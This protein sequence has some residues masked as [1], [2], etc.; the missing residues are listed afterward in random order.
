M[1]NRHHKTTNRSLAL[2]AAV[3]GVLAST[4]IA[5]L[6]PHREY[7]GIG[8]TIPMQVEM[9]DGEVVHSECLALLR[10]AI[11]ETGKDQNDRPDDS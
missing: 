3:V 4:A 2:A 7:Y 11:T 6:T 9:P 5:Q 10:M 8:R 1:T